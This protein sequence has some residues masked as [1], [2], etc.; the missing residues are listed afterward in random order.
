LLSRGVDDL[1]HQFG[2]LP[3]RAQ[4]IYV[5]AFNDAWTEYHACA[6]AQREAIAHRVAS[7]AV[8]RK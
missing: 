7:A 5:S 3:L 4:E 2:T 8:K 1:P 6:P